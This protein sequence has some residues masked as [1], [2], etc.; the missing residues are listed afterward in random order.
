MEPHEK[1]RLSNAM[2]GICSEIAD[3]VSDDVKPGLTEGEAQRLSSRL[4]NLATILEK[5]GSDPN[6]PLPQDLPEASSRGF[7]I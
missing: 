5:I 1:A 3:I 2:T 4:I 7:T 6:N